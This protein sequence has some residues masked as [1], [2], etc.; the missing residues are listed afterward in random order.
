MVADRRLT[1][2]R[3]WLRRAEGEAD[4]FD[5]FFAAWVA[6]VVA[7]QIVRDGIGGSGGDD[8]DRQ[9][10]IDYFR[11]KKQVVIRALEKHQTEMDFLAR[12]RGTRFR[13]HIVDTGNPQLREMFEWLSRHYTNQSPMGD[14]ERVEAVAELLNRIRNNVFH[15]MKVYDDKEDTRLL[16]RVN[17]ILIDILRPADEGGV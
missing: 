13:N 16:E 2:V 3:T 10:V 6:L 1:F 8:S 9:R 5:R 7:A 14:D 17:P 12:R 4:P 11:E 15:G